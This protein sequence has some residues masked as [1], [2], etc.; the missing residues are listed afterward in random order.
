[1]PHLVIVRR[2]QRGLYE[3]FKAH[4]ERSG[5][6]I[7]VLDPVG[8]ERRQNSISVPIERRRSQRRI[9]ISSKQEKELEEMG[10]TIIEVR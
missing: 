1:M 4:M 9:P 3:Y 8:G 6:V 10:F 5:E 7:V 2:D